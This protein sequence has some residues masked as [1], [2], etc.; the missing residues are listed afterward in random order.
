MRACKSIF[1]LLFMAVT[2]VTAQDPHFTQFHRIPAFYNPA[3][4]GHGVEHIRLSMLYRNQWA[5]V[6]SPFTTQALF[7]DKQVSKVGLGANIINNTSGEAGMRQMHLN[8]MLSYRFAFGENQFAAGMQLGLI[9]K[10]FDPSKMTFDDQFNGDNGFTNPTAE[11]F[12]YSKLTR[13]DF[14]A[15]IFWTNG[16]AGEKMFS[17]FA[18]AGLMHITQPKES[19]ILEDNYMPRKITAQAGT[20][21][22]MSEHLHITPMAVYAS[23]QAS[24]EIMYGMLF[25]LPVKER[26]RIETG[27]LYRQDDAL[28]FYAG[29]QFNSLMVGASYDMNVSGL[30]GGPGAFEFS[31][32]YIPLPKAKKDKSKNNQEAPSSHKKSGPAKA[33]DRDADGIPD[34]KDECPD[35]PGDVALKGC[36]DRDDPMGDIDNDG[37]LNPADK[38]PDKGGPSWNKGCPVSDIDADGDGFPDKVDDCP[39]LK[40]SLSTRGCPDTDND[41]ITDTADKCPYEKGRKEFNGCPDPKTVRIKADSYHLGNIEFETN[42]TTIR[43]IYKLDLIEPASD[44][45]YADSSW[46]VIISGHTDGEGSDAYNMVL[47]QDRADAIRDM[48]IRK[49]IPSYK[50]TTIA[51]GESMPLRDNTSEEGKERNRRAEIHLIR[52]KK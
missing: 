45:V 51:Y 50:I 5:S 22:R 25:T 10:S 46:K 11:T 3:A 34:D 28:A 6:A 40:G 39:Y 30:S 36:P 4:A 24:S 7:F 29:Y 52:D 33:M 1:I 16:K 20:A 38:C 35:V 37:V 2:A 26:N 31:L 43:G 41:G 49:G 17:P 8:G 21:I 32:T 42:S 47:S 19:F 48:M 18:G 15:G 13:P 23:Q 27:L 44:S 12:S 9:Q 14:G